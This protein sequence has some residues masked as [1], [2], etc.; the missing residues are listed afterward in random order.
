MSIEDVNRLIIQRFIVNFGA[1]VTGDDDQLYREYERA[2][3]GIEP[4]ILKAAADIVI[5]AQE[6]RIWPTVG[7]CNKAVLAVATRLNAERERAR[8][9]AETLRLQSE[10]PPVRSEAARA[11]IDDLMKEAVSNLQ[12]P[13]R[14][15]PKREEGT[16]DDKA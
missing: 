10:K 14:L 13:D 3:A 12:N 4:E 5:D 11:R 9:R 6:M 2:L 7:A 8:A 16:P 1:P 15:K